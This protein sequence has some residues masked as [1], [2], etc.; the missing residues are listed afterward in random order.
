MSA[1]DFLRDIGKHFPVN[2][3]LARESVAARLGGDGHQLHR[4]QLPDPAGHT[5]SWSC[6][7]GTAARCRS[8]AATSGATSPPGIDL[9]RR[10]EPATT[11]TRLTTP[12]I[13]KADGTKFGK[14]AGGA[15]WLDPELTSPY[16]FYQF[17]L[18]A[19]DRDVVQVPARSSA[20]GPA[21]RSRSWR[22]RSAERPA[23]RAAQRALAEELTTLRPRRGRVRRGDRGVRGAV[24]PGRRWTSCDARTLAAALAEVPHGRGRR[25][26]ARRSWTCWPRAAWWQA[27]RRPAARS[28]EGGAYLNN[29]KVTDE[30]HVP[31]GGR[32]AARPLPGAAPGQA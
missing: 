22:R 29:V 12:L 16:A 7:G 6:T 24:R 11:C 3:M 5:T 13:T 26:W 10:V 2:Q 21:R 23:A 9:I 20:S 25:G 1:I 4:V 28:K 19:D 30:T 27:S 14:T 18:N 32:P 17:W 31:V 8:A 15:V